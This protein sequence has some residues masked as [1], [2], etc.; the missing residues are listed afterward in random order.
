MK[1]WILF[2][3]IGNF[4]LFSKSY[5]IDYHLKSFY[6]NEDYKSCYNL[7]KLIN[8]KRFINKDL[9]KYKIKIPNKCTII[10][11]SSEYFELISLYKIDSN[12]F[13]YNYIHN[14]IIYDKFFIMN[15]NFNRW[16]NLLNN[17]K[18]LNYNKESEIIIK[19]KLNE[20]YNFI[21]DST[22]NKIF[23]NN[24]EFIKKI[25]N[26]N[27]K[28]I[29]DGETKIKY[30]DNYINIVLE[31]QR[32]VN[33]DHIQKYFLD[34]LNQIER[35]IVI[36]SFTKN[37]LH[38]ITTESHTANDIKRIIFYRTTVC[39]GYANIL[40]ELFKQNKIESYIAYLEVIPKTKSY[41]I[42]NYH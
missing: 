3:I 21:D 15:I 39:Q 35:I 19:M 16:V 40:F 24:K 38:Y 10:S 30:I 26:L 33:I 34:D 25:K 7:S 11:D 27:I 17:S 14:K 12:Q 28:S 29:D 2:I 8:S 36:F 32:F 18:I 37:Y 9:L 42:N 23:I 6:I 13:Y 22:K 20:C 41:V 1:K 4:N 5:N 31:N